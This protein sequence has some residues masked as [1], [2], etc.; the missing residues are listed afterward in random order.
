[1]ATGGVVTDLDVGDVLGPVEFT[2][3]PFVVRE[4]SH[5]VEMHHECFQSANELFMPPTLIHLDKLRLYNHA[6]PGGTGPTARIHYE[7]DAEVLAPVRPGDRLSVSGEVKER[8]TKKG[9]EYVLIEMQLKRVSD[10]ELLVRYFDRVI[11]AY[12]TRDEQAA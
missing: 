7:Y 8:Y 9:R 3:S 5:A 10:G 2:L 12:K 4:Y 6:C 1:M 11:L